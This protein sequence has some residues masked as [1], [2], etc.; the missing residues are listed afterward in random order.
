D[1][2]IDRLTADGRWDGVIVV[3]VD[4][5]AA[6][7][8]DE[9]GPWVNRRMHDWVATAYAAPAQGGEGAAY[10]RFLANTLKPEIDRRYH[11]MPDR[12]HTGVGGSSMGGLIS[13]YAGL[14]RPDVFSKVMAMST[15]VWFAEDGGA[16]LSRNQLLAEMRGRP[17]PRDVRFYV[18]VGTN[19]RSRDVDPDV[20]DD[21]GRPVSYPRAYVDGS[22]AVV[23]AL[24]AGGVPASNVDFVVDEGAVHHESAWSRRF[25]GAVTWLYQ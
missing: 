19:E 13:L 8:W 23:A 22:R 15:A 20:V 18:D 12:A 10:V 25:A 21:A 7:R 24:R 6:L 17:L 3:G 9:Y 11:T 4:N 2:T 14:T 16:W 1:E 5:G